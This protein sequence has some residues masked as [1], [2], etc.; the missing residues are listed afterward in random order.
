MG[1]GTLARGDLAG[2]GRP[3]RSPALAGCADTDERPGEQS[4]S[5]SPTSSATVEPGSGTVLRLGDDG[6]EVALQVGG[7]GRRLP[8]RVVHLGGAGGRRR[9]R[10]DQPGHLRRG[11]PQPVVDRDGPAR[12]HRDA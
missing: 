11:Q 6:A 4:S 1:T 2:L 12:R 8:A 3:A 10:D 5:A 9:R 7:T